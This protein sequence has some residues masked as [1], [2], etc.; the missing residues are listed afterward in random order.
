MDRF[1]DFQRM[2]HRFSDTAWLV[3]CAAQPGEYM[4][5]AHIDVILLEIIRRE[6]A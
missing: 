2:V 4:Q 6:V 5:Q 1:R 3:D